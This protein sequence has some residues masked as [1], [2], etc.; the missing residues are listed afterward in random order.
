MHYGDRSILGGW[1]SCF[2]K[3]RTIKSGDNLVWLN[4][5]HRPQNMANPYNHS[6]GEIDAR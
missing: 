3:Q 1:Q 5:M 2:K 6:T 4:S